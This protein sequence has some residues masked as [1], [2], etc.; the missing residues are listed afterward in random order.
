MRIIVFWCQPLKKIFMAKYLNTA[1]DLMQAASRR[2]TIVCKVRI[3]IFRTQ[4]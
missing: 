2:G 4:P 1:K 3:P